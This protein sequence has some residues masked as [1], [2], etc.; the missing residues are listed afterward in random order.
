M[1][2][3]NHGVEGRSPF[4]IFVNKQAECEWIDIRASPAFACRPRLLINPLLPKER[5][6]R[7]YKSNA[8]QHTFLC[9]ENASS[10]FSEEQNTRDEAQHNLAPCIYK[11]KGFIRRRTTFFNVCAPIRGFRHRSPW[12]GFWC[13]SRRNC[14]KGCR[15]ASK[16]IAAAARHQY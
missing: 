1:H 16:W 10:R 8:Q 11:P 5:F 2:V 6:A 4:S 9:T 14:W 7:P 15:R 3:W 12:C 13:W